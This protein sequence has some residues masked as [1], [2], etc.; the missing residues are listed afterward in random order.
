MNTKSSPLIIRP[1]KS[2]IRTLV[3]RY[4]RE[5]DV[6]RVISQ[7]LSLHAEDELD[8]SNSASVD[9]EEVVKEVMTRIELFN[10]PCKM[11]IQME[12]IFSSQRVWLFGDELHP[13]KSLKLMDHCPTG[14]MWGYD[15]SGPSQLA[16]AVCLELMG[17][18]KALNIYHDFKRKYITTIPQA[19]FKIDFEIDY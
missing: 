6:R 3:K 4:T 19:N 15:G 18:D 2:F 14:F 17:E 7:D 1:D 13:E 9:F 5:D 12:G 11:S 8:E 16:L 10:K